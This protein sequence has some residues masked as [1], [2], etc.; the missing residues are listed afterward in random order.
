[1]TVSQVQICEILKRS[2]ERPVLL[3]DGD[4]G[5]AVAV[6]GGVDAFRCQEKHGHGALDP[7]LGVKE[8]VYQT[9]LLVDQRGHQLR[10]VDLSAAHAHKVDVAVVIGLLYQLFGIADHP[11]CGQGIDSQMGTD[12]QG[13]G[14]HV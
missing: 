1:M 13:L 6:P 3:A 12:Q 4:G 7:L 2:A 9:V 5:T 14:I 10:I 11:D 8:S